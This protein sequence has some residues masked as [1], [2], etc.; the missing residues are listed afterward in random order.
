VE[1]EVLL[2]NVMPRWI[3]VVRARLP[4]TELGQRLLPLFDRVYAAVR[5]GDIPRG[6]HNVVVYRGADAGDLA[7]EVGI[8][9][10]EP[11]E[12]VGISCARKRLQ[13]SWP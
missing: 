4:W 1:N 2:Q 3:A 11:F 8:E 10:A 9:V 6:G 12:M 13:E 5:T 7:L